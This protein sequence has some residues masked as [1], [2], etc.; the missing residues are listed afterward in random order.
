MSRG[1]RFSSISQWFR[2]FFDFFVDISPEERLKVLLMTGSFFF[3]I[4]CYTVTKELK[5]AIFVSTVGR[6]YLPYAKLLSMIVLVPG[7]F[8]YSRLVDVL[9]RYQ[10]LYTYA[11]LYGIGGLVATY[12]LGHPT[13]GLSNTDT[14][15]WRL[16]GWLFY[17]FIEGYSPFVVSVFWAFA[18]SITAPARAHK[19]YAFMVAGSKLGGIIMASAAWLLLTARDSLGNELFS[20]TVSHQILLGGSSACLLIVPLIIRFLIK[21][22]PGHYLHGYE[23][24]YQ[25]EKQRAAEGE[26]ESARTS[27]LSGLSLL[28]RYPYVLGIYGMIF[29]WEVVNVVLQ[30]LRLEVGQASTNSVAGLTGFLLNRRFLLM[31]LVL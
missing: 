27:I 5:D 8:L 11:F 7:I 24:V 19:Q 15:P 13:I 31:Q 1:L 16:F 18:N 21:N 23:A 4:G 26:Q 25:A 9:R 20:D 29:F 6:E 10:L 3:V 30:Y 2:K 17:F 22:V 28:V 14:G 12:L